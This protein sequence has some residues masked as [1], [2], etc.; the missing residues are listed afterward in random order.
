MGTPA[1][2]NMGVCEVTFSGTNLGYT[3]GGVQVNYT[4]E[5]MDVIVDQ[6]D[7]PIDSYITGQNFTVTVPLAE[8]NWAVMETLLPGATLVTDGAKKKLVLSG[9]AGVS[10]SDLSAE[11][12]VNPTNEDANYNVTVHHAIPTPSISF[13]YDKENV[14]VYSVTFKAT[15]GASG[16]VTFGDTTASA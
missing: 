6:E 15:V 8:E 13:T 9:A 1:Y 16:F 4:V 5:T 10:L 7:A 12:I 11:L 2:V 3:K 14:R